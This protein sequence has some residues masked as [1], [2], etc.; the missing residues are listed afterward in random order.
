MM[1]MGFLLLKEE[2]E[3]EEEEEETRRRRRRKRRERS[4][5]D[6]I[7]CESNKKEGAAIFLPCWTLT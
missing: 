1:S 4:N 6:I 7:P 3:E 2:E 5:V